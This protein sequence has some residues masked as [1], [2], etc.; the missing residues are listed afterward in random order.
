MGA[1]PGFPLLPPF[2]VTKRGGW[3]GGWECPWGATDLC[4]HDREICGGKCTDWY[5]NM[6]RQKHTPFTPRYSLMLLLCV[7]ID[8]ES[9]ALCLS[10]DFRQQTYGTLARVAKL[11]W[12]HFLL[13]LWKTPQS[14]NSKRSVT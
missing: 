10:L 13:C 2:D 11:V 3:T 6:N 4:K 8:S 5:S 9:T 1:G 7:C 14:P 12:R